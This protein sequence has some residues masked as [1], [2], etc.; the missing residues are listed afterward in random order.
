MRLYPAQSRV[1]LPRRQHAFPCLVI[2]PR[3]LQLEVQVFGYLPSEV[4]FKA[5]PFLCRFEEAPR[6]AVVK[7]AKAKSARVH[8]MIE[9]SSAFDFGRAAKDSP[10][11]Y[12]NQKRS[13]Y[14]RHDHL[15]VSSTDLEGPE[16]HSLLWTRTRHTLA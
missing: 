15:P 14:K 8:H 10:K 3:C 12:H 6:R 5:S 2:D 9:D 16:A 7:M 1:N 4:H 13:Y 11:G